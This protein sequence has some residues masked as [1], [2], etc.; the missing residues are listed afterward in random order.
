MYK[1]VTWFAVIANVKQKK[2]IALQCYWFLLYINVLAHCYCE[3]EEGY[4]IAMFTIV[5]ATTG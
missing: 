1:C 3:A 5:S 2:V 4:R